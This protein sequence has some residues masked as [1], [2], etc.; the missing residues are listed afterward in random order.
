MWFVEVLRW[1]AGL[2]VHV[3]GVGALVAG[4]EAL[5]EGLA[6]WYVDAP[7]RSVRR[8]LMAYPLGH[9]IDVSRRA[10]RGDAGVLAW[11]IGASS[12]AMF[13]ITNWIFGIGIALLA[14]C[15]TGYAIYR[16]HQD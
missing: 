7:R 8:K 12:V 11:M 16:I 13:F 6:R 2:G 14:L 3:V 10:Y 1:V 15:I 4:G 5:T 9:A